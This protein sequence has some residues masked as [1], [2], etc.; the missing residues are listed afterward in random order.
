MANFLDHISLG[1]SDFVKARDF[2]NRVLPTLGIALLWEQEGM[3]GYGMTDEEDQFGLQQDQGVA[4]HG[5]HLAFQ[6]ADRAS[7]D[8]FH[9]EALAAGARDNGGPGVR[10]EYAGTYYAAF[11]FDPDGNRIEAVFHD[12][13][14]T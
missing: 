9:A 6:A 1:V 5:T 8:R 4:R 13:E 12:P 7:V 11:V 3:A 14:G 2:Y 10:G